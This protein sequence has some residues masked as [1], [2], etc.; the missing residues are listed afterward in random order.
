VLNKQR[1][2]FDLLR[3]RNLPLKVHDQMQAPGLHPSPHSEL[4][5]LLYGIETV[6]VFI[7]EY[8]VG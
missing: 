6:D 4:E 5:N 2:T 7:P 1:L 3:H 8:L